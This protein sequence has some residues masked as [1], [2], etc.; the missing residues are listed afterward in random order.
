MK[1]AEDETIRDKLLFRTKDAIDY[2][3]YLLL[4]SYF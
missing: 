1:K 3:L 4:F 2:L